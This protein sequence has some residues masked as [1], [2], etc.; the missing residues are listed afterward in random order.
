MKFD[1]SERQMCANIKLN[2]E[3]KWNVKLLGAFL[4]GD[5]DQDQ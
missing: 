5:L 3:W 4:W 1:L 2:I